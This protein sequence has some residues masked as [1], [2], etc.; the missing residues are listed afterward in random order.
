MLV[1]SYLNSAYVLHNKQKLCKN[2]FIR[3]F[4]L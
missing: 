1:S 3:L 4:L 2:T